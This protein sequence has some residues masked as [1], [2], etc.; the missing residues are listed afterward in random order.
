MAN[1]VNTEP[2]I[3]YEFVA[4]ASNIT[5]KGLNIIDNTSINNKG[6]F[7]DNLKSIKAHNNRII[8]N[9][10]EFIRAIVTVGKDGNKKLKGISKVSENLTDKIKG[11][12]AKQKSTEKG[13]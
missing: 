7:K 8:K 13:R 4:I 5:E 10:D 11:L 1:N 12:F 2:S 3:S 9:K 6:L